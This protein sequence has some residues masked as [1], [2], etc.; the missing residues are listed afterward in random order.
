MNEIG[1]DSVLLL[2]PLAEQVAESSHVLRLRQRKVDNIT[3]YQILAFA[4]WG[5]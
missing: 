3:F 1:Y 5:A 2:K 4:F